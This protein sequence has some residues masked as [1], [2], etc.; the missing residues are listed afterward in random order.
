MIRI[1]RNQD[2]NV[3][4]VTLNE[5]KTL[6]NPFYLFVFESVETKSVTRIVLVDTSPAK[7]R[8]NRFQINTSFFDFDGWYN[9]T[10]YQQDDYQN[11]DI[12]L[13]NGIVETGR[14]FVAATEIQ[15]YI[16]PNTEVT[17][18]EYNQ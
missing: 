11:T 6:N 17:F 14:L 13:T 5:R 4:A 3:F 10:V 7:D 1:E 15:N 9:Y 18:T 8:Y 12:E 2:V 16:T